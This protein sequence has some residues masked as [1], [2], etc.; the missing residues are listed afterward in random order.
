MWGCCAV[1]DPHSWAAVDGDTSLATLS[2]TVTG[3]Q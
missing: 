1:M 3:E 2:D